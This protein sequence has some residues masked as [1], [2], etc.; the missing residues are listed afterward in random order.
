M[1]EFLE[2]YDKKVKLIAKEFHTVYEKNAPDYGYRS[3]N[4][5]E[6]PWGDVIAWKKT[7]LLMV[8]D[9]LI[10]RD[11]IQFGSKINDEAGRCD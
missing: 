6:V 7:L 1:N 8:I 4:T 11:I 10:D 9:D 3:R 2:E 5:Q